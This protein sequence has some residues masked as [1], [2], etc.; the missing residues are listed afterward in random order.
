[1]NDSMM[2]ESMDKAIELHK[3]HM[4]DPKSAT[5][6]SQKDLME[7]LQ[8]CKGEM[9]ES[10]GMEKKPGFMSSLMSKHKGGDE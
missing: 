5:P 10:G 7:L 6:A 9:S 8:K 3:K 4:S 2:K 1:M